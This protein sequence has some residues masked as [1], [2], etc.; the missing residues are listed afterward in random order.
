MQ[1][2]N[3]LSVKKPHAGTISMSSGDA[4]FAETLVPEADG[5]YTAK[6][7]FRNRLTGEELIDFT[8]TGGDVPAFHETVVYPLV[9]LLSEPALPGGGMLTVSRSQDLKLVWTR[10]IADGAFLVQADSGPLRANVHLN[11]SVNADAGTLTIPRRP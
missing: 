2:W 8:A 11:C 6:S 4:G 1:R 5:N 9:F 10:G 7:S 3:P